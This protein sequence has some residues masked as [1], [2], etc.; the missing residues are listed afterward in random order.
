MVCTT[1]FSLR[2]LNRRYV[3]FF[4]SCLFLPHMCVAQ[5]LIATNFL[6][7]LRSNRTPPFFAK[8]GLIS[9]RATP[10]CEMNYNRRSPS[11]LTSTVDQNGPYRFSQYGIAAL[12]SLVWDEKLFSAVDIIGF[13]SQPLD[14]SIL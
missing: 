1:Y 7:N 6:H 5:P 10:N 13:Q 14:A 4:M 12:S 11:V 3:E 9:L 8:R 2:S